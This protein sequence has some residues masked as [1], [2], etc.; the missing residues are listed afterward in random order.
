[1]S[2]TFA[3]LWIDG[4]PRE[5]GEAGS[6]GLAINNINQIGGMYATPDGYGHAFVATGG[7]MID[8]GT[9]PWGALDLRVRA[10]RYGGNRGI[11]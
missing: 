2:T 4:V 10:K 11:W 6:Y 1:M 8:L 7:V 9:T 3:T 5:I